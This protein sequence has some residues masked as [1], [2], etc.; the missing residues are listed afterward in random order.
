[1]DETV[2]MECEEKD[3]EELR[4]TINIQKYPIIVKGIYIEKD[5]DRYFAFCPNQ[6]PSENSNEHTQKCQI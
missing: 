4:K 1:M 5:A 6:N 3:I 2:E